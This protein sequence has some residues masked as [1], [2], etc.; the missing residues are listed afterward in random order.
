MSTTNNIIA[1]LEDNAKYELV[2]SDGKLFVS[3][4]LLDSN[5]EI[6]K[7][8][9]SGKFKDINN[10]SIDLKQFPKRYFSYLFNYLINNS[11]PST[12]IELMEFANIASYLCVTNFR[13]KI[14]SRI[15]VIDSKDIY[16]LV[17]NHLD[18]FLNDD[19][20]SIFIN[21][22]ISYLP[23][24]LASFNNVVNSQ[25]RF[26]GRIDDTFPATISAK[27]I[28]GACLGHEGYCC[29]HPPKF[30][31]NEITKEPKLLRRTRCC[32]D[33][34]DVKTSDFEALAEIAN[35]ELADDNTP[36]RRERINRII[37][38]VDKSHCCKH[39]REIN[40]M[41]NILAFLDF[42]KKI[43]SGTVYSGAPCSRAVDNDLHAFRI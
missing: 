30:E 23:R 9:S 36:E 7:A 17:E 1:L 40:G 15:P 2:F 6:L 3:K 25:F 10:S 26:H 39:I 8:K 16:I 41:A 24:C 18:L 43:L 32:Y 19:V 33:P 27:Y 13:E 38:F 35:A 4:Q 5:C 14:I 20:F 31:N 28:K 37:S 12:L 42:V 21:E 22:V 11:V 34:Q 29:T